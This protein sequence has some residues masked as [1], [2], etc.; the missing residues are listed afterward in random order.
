M[1]AARLLR[2]EL[3]AEQL[4]HVGGI[5]SGN[6][7]CLGGAATTMILQRYQ[8]AILCDGAPESRTNMHVYNICRK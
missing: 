8:R 3:S 7:S 2:C 4:C 5:A 1:A 6:L